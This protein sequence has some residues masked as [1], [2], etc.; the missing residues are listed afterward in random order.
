MLS[1]PDSGVC[2]EASQ[3][4]LPVRDSYTSE[5]R[6]TVAIGGEPASSHLSATRS[7][8]NEHDSLHFPGVLIWC[9]TKNSSKPMSFPHRGREVPSRRS[10]EFL[11]LG[12]REGFGFMV[13]QRSM[14]HPTCLKAGKR[15]DGGGAWNA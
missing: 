14:G 3:G 11:A 15:G 6:T 13:M 4:P 5:D 2:G 10:R 7:L 8:W 9:G 1:G 12:T